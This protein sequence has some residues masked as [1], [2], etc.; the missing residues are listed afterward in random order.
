MATAEAELE[1]V[2]PREVGQLEL[3]WSRF[4]QHRL[5]LLGLVVVGLFIMVALLAPWITP[6]D[7][8][9]ID[10]TITGIHANIGFAPP[11]SQHLLGTDQLNRDMVSRLMYA[12]RVSLL[13][14]FS[15]MILSIIVGMAVGSLAGYYGGWLDA[16]LMRFTD[17]ILSFPFLPLLL[18]LSAMIRQYRFEGI[19]PDVVQVLTIVGVLV[20][21]G[22]MESARLI[23]GAILSLRN[24][25]FVEAARALGASDLRLLLRHLIPN[26]LPPIIVSGTLAVGNYIILESAISF[27]GVGISPPTATWGNMLTDFQSI[28]LWSPIAAVYPGACIFLTVLS[29]NFIGDGLRDA[30]DPRTLIRRG[31]G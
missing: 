4:R 1:L 21:L 2:A 23:R 15:A 8:N 14:G 22:W 31:A 9:Y 27:L 7:P 12:G 6:Y 11:S 19:S 3:I 24:Q 30:L 26:S 17:L 13:I 28:M 29:I 5:A 18:L 16:L 25:D 20:S 10:R